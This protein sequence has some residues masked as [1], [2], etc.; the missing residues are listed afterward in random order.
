[1]TPYREILRLHSQGTCQR[2][3][4]ACCGCSRNTV[5]SVL[6]KAEEHQLSWP[7]PKEMTDEVIRKRLFPKVV[8]E[9]GRKVCSSSKNVSKRSPKRLAPWST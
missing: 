1:M 7:L 2:S 8:Q 6:L 9:S 5:A 3:I 4:A